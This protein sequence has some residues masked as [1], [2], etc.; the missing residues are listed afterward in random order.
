MSAQK[1]LAETMLN[2]IYGGVPTPD[3]YE[4]NIQGPLTE[5][6][7]NNFV[8]SRMLK[9]GTKQETVDEV[10]KDRVVFPI[11]TFDS[12]NGDGSLEDFLETLSYENFNWLGAACINR[13]L[14]IDGKEK[15][16]KPLPNTSTSEEMIAY[17]KD[18]KN[19]YSGRML[20]NAS[21]EV[22]NNPEVLYASIKYRKCG[23]PIANM[24]KEHQLNVDIVRKVLDNDP[25]DICYIHPR[26]M[27]NIDAMESLVR[28]PKHSNCI[29]YAPPRIK[30]S[31][32]LA[33]IGLYLNTQSLTCLASFGAEIKD[34]ERF[35]LMA[36]VRDQEQWRWG[37]DRLKRKFFYLEPSVHN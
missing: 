11:W 2:T 30:N 34:N 12:W 14:I 8:A 6:P 1:L 16:L 37:S 18:T 21:N 26:M 17:I 23:F 33:T 5:E 7:F 32:K 15:E 3:S 22:L 28:H 9:S 36:Y 19:D 25:T 31:K 24:S 27:D 4:E 13:A 35:F 10:M 20:S 29:Q